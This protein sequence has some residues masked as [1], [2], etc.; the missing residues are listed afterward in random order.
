MTREQ[1]KILAEFLTDFA[2]KETGN[3]KS[4]VKLNCG[5]WYL[6]FYTEDGSFFNTKKVG[7]MDSDLNY[8]KRQIRNSVT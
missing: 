4:I 1:E 8:V 3:D 6:G 5:S 7:T 2:V